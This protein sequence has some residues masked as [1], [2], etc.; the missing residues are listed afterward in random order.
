M[1]ETTT[2]AISKGLRDKLAG[3]GSKRETYEEIIR[4]LI[5]TVG[6]KAGAG[7]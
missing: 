1:S 5:E 4:R 3:L 6:A 2:I 7:K